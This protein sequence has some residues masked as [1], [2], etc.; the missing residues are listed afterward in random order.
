MSRKIK[1]TLSYPILELMKTGY[2]LKAY[3]PIVNIR[4]IKLKGKLSIGKT[5]QLRNTRMKNL[6]PMK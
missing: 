6:K 5:P 1:Q 2:P 4:H 3:P